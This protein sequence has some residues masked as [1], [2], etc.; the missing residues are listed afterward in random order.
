MSGKPTSIVDAAEQYA[1]ALAQEVRAKERGYSFEA[2]D[3]AIRKRKEKRSVLVEMASNL[4]NATGA[5]P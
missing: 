3:A 4:S 1:Q 5:P 2:R